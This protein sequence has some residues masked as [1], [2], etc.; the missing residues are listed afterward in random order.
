MAAR[1]NVR[2]RL[3]PRVV[4]SGITLGELEK[5]IK[6]ALE[7]S[8]PEVRYQVR[9]EQV[10][11]QITTDSRTVIVEGKSRQNYFEVS[12]IVITDNALVIVISREF[13]ELEGYHGKNGR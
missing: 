11:F 10:K 13:E 1:T 12:D 2:N 5:L 3:P 4:H 7:L 8:N 6:G 9:Q